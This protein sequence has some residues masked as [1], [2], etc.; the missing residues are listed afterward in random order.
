MPRTGGS[1]VSVDDRVREEMRALLAASDSTPWLDVTAGK[2]LAAARRHYVD[3][4]LA[5]T[6]W[7]TEGRTVNLFTWRGD[8]TQD[9]LACLLRARG[10]VAENWGICLRLRGTTETEVGDALAEIAI[11]PLPGPAEILDRET[12]G[13]PEKWDWALPDRLFFAGYAS[14]RLNLAAARA[15][16][17]ELALR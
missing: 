12:L 6:G 8:A 14:R 15:L 17:A 5:E 11:A 9:A 1:G 13:S 10:L 7:V 2:V 3:L 4:N 16:C